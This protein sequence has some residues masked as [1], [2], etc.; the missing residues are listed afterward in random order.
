MIENILIA[1]VALPIGLGLMVAG[2]FGLWLI[3][4]ALYYVVCYGRLP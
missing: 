4:T 2:F 3:G 1:I